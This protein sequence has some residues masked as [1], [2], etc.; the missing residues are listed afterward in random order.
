MEAKLIEFVRQNPGQYAKTRLRD[1]QSGKTKDPFRA[2]KAELE[3][4]IE[5]LLKSGRLV[6]RPPT[7]EERQRFGHTARVIQVLDVP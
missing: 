5:T 7:A 6:N 2:S 3:G 1:T 4:A